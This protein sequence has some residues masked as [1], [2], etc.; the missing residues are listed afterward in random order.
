MKSYKTNKFNFDL[1][2]HSV[3]SGHGTQDTITDL[4]RSASR[5][6]L[7]ALGIT[8]HAPSFPGSAGESYFCGLTRAPRSRFG[9]DIY[10]GVELD[11]LDETGRVALSGEIIGRLD[12]AIVSLHSK[13]ISS[14]GVSGNTEGLIAAFDHP[15]VKF[16]GHPDDSTF[17]L[18]LERLLFHAKQKGVYPEINNASLMPGA[19]RMNCRENCLQ[20]L[21]ICRRLQIPVL[22]SSDSHGHE[23]VGDFEYSERLLSET[24]FPRELILNYGNASDIL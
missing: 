8:D 5:Q 3:A 13:V 22:L 19:Y 16:I 14:M 1:H 12:Y 4:C 2:T 23:H 24:G 11:V 21:E 9:L 10:Y 20:I 17:P 6:G 18:D 15:G 7:S